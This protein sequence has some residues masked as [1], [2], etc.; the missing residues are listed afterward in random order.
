MVNPEAMLTVMQGGDPAS[1]DSYLDHYEQLFFLRDTL[2]QAHRNGDDTRDLVGAVFDMLDE[3]FG[4]MPDDD[5]RERAREIITGLF[6]NPREI[7]DLVENQIAVI[8]DVAVNVGLVRSLLYS[9][10]V[11]LDCDAFF[12]WVARYRFYMVV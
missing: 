8:E 6:N 9:Y 5:D 11:N 3:E 2:V 10:G 12:K 4:E 1:I 7:E